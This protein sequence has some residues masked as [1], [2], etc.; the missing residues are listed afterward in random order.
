MYGA[1][2]LLD[3]IGGLLA[4]RDFYAARDI[5]R[6]GTDRAKRVGHI[7]SSQVTRQNDP[8]ARARLR[9]LEC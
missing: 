8:E 1:A 6:E 2:K 5:H 7:C 3:E 9:C 4:A